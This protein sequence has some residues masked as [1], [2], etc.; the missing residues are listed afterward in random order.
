MTKRHT[1]VGGLLGLLLLAGCGTPAEVEY[2]CGTSAVPPIAAESTY[3]ANGVLGYQWYSAPKS[4]VAEP[5]ERPVV[6]QPLDGD[7]WDPNDKYEVANGIVVPKTTKAP[8]PT[9]KPTPT[10]SGK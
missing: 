10:R 4:D 8:T 9:K 6:D 3:C 2:A 7:W 1:V 5:S